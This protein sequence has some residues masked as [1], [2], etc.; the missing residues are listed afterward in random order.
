MKKQ[1]ISFVHSVSKI[2]MLGI[3]VLLVACMLQ[4]C[5]GSSNNDDEE[6]DYTSTYIVA[7]QTQVKKFLTSP[8]SAEFSWDTDDYTFEVEGKQVT[9]SG[10]VDADNAFGASMRSNFEVVVTFLNDDYDKY[11]VNSV[12]IDGDKFV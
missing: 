10:Y 1:K 5:F 12:V 9:I 2:F 7:A 6:E 8:S 4:G 11:E 3:S